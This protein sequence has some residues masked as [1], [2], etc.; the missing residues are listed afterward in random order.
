MSID[1]VRRFHVKFGLPNGEGEP[2]PL[3]EEALNFRCDFLQEELDEFM[4]SMALGEITDA[5]DALL[6]LVYVAQGTA[7]MMNISAEQWHAGMEVVQACNMTKERAT[8]AS[9]SKRGTTLDVVKPRDWI[10]P[11]PGLRAI[12]GLPR[13][14]E[15]DDHGA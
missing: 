14:A 13:K 1:A 15:G 12:L 9:Q 8:D 4:A 11:E 6:D 5:F 7:L 10:G 2:Q 3:D